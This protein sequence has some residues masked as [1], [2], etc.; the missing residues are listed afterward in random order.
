PSNP[1]PGEGEEEGVI[2]ESADTEVS[3]DSVKSVVEV[4]VGA[5]PR[6]RPS[7]VVGGSPS[8]GGGFEGRGERGPGG[9]VSLTYAQLDARSNQLAHR[10]RR[11]GVGPETLVAI[12]IERSV[13]L[14]VALL[15]ILKSGGAYLPIDPSWPSERIAYMLDDAQVPVLLTLGRLRTNLP[16]TSAVVLELDDPATLAGEPESPVV[17]AADD[18]SALA[19]VI[20]TSGSTGRPKG[21][22]NSHRGIV[23]RLLWMAPAMDLGPDDR[24]LQKTPVSFDV[25]VWELFV[26]LILGARLVYAAPGRHGDPD[27][28]VEWIEQQ[29][30]TVCHFVPSMLQAFVAAAAGIER[31]TSLRRVVASG[32]ALPPDLVARWYAR[33][34]V[35]LW[36][37][38]GPTETAVEVS[39]HATSARTAGAPVPIGRPLPNT[40]LVVIDASFRPVPPGVPGELTIGGVQVGRGYRNRPALTAAMFVPDPFGD[41]PGARMYRTGDL[42][43]A[44]PN[45][46]IE[47]LGRIDHQVKIRGFRIELGEIEA[48]LAEHP[49]VQAAVVLARPGAGGDSRLVGY[50]TVVAGGDIEEGGHGGPPLRIDSDA[51]GSLT[52]AAVGAAPRGRPPGPSLRDFLATRLPE[53][54]IPTAFVTLEAF[55]LTPSGKVDRKALPEPAEVAA[56]SGGVAPRTATEEILAGVFAEVLGVERVSADA[57]FF[58][59]GGHSL[60]ATR[61]VARLREVFAVEIP[62]RAVFERPTVAALAQTVDAARGGPLAAAPLTRDVRSSRRDRAELSFA[63]E[64]LWFLAELAPG[65][66]V[67]NIRA[68]LSLHGPLDIA[69]L[70]RALQAVVDHHDTLRTTFVTEGGRPFQSIA[71]QLAIDLAVI[72]L[73]ALPPAERESAW[74]RLDLAEQQLGFDLERGPLLR[75]QLAIL[76]AAEHRLTLTVHHIVSDGWSFGVFLDDLGRAYRGESLPP[77][78]VTY[79]DFGVWQRRELSGAALERRVD[80]WR[81]LL[82]DVPRVLELPTDRP[83]PP[84]PSGLGAAVEL[85]LGAELS[86]ALQAFA[87]HHG[88]TPFLVLLAAYGTLLGRLAGQSVVA[89]GAPVA[90]R[91]R[92][93]VAHL[94]GFFVNTL[95]LP[96]D[97]SGGVGFAELV[98]R[99]REATLAGFA[100]ADLPFEKLVEELTPQR[101]PSRNPLF[102]A[103]LTLQ[104]PTALPDLPGITCQALPRPTLTAKFDLATS[105]FEDGGRLFGV[106]EFATELFDRATVERWSGQLRTLLAAGLAHP[107]RAVDTLSLVSAAAARELV[108]AAHGRPAEPTPVT[109]LHGLVFAQIAR[110][111]AAVALA[112]GDATLTYAELGEQARQVAARLRDL[113][114]GPETGVAL[115]LPRSLELPVVLLGVLAAGGAYLPIDPGYPAERLAAMLD[116]ARPTVLVAGADLSTDLRA[117]AAAGGCRVV[118]LAD[119]LAPGPE[120]EPVRV[121]PEQAAYWLFTSGSTGRP[122]AVVVPH[123]AIVQQMVWL[124]RE[125][126][127]TAGD[128]LLQKTPMSFDASVWEFFAPL[129]AGAVLALAVPG[130]EREPAVLVTELAHHRATVLQGVPSLL[131]ALCGEPGFSRLGHL[132][133]LFSGGE[134]LAADL[135]ASLRAALPGARLVNLYGPTETTVQVLFEAWDG[136]EWPLTVAL[137][138]PVDG[139]WVAVVDPALEPVP[140]GVVGEI[141][142]GGAAVSRGYRARPA[143]TAESFV[144]D[145]HAA[146]PGARLYRTGDLGRLRADGRLEYLGRADG[147]VKLRGVRLEL[148]EV[149]AALR[150]HPALADAVAKV[151]PGAGSHQT[152]GD[153][154]LVAYYVIRPGVAAPEITALRDHLAL[155]LP[156]ALVPGGYVPLAALPLAPNGKVDRRALPPPPAGRVETKPFV[157]PRSPREQLVAEIFA[158]VLGLTEPVGAEDSF[159]ALG[160]HSLR[161]AQVVGRLRDRTGVALPLARLFDSSATPAALALALEAALEAARNESGPAAS[162]ELVVWPGDGPFPLSFGQERLWFLDR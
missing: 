17:P 120:A 28:L 22:L 132:T 83:R 95:V 79:G 85:D 123:G 115:A 152:L 112:F 69:A 124:G 58:D 18:P 111:P 135:A 100:H 162:A 141:V 67:Y 92:A 1:R 54:M 147:Q 138:R 161:A 160:G 82:A 133:A 146:L 73:A 48:A 37:L 122:K 33:L 4:A 96:V 98:G 156:E 134:A 81:T 71:E 32:E 39:Y 52:T 143:A 78:P 87:R 127:L 131:R 13:E 64:R 114:V 11:L 108:L 68:G 113:G 101:D 154:R 151:W 66:P 51:P 61:V 155:R 119:L 49:D 105:L 136:G 62:L 129:Q 57:S 65:S 41:E 15:G 38:Y 89:V 29:K 14:S 63:Q 5:A 34:D 97:R 8:P 137:G 20:Y 24:F 44:L 157:A 93:E 56:A 30:V 43:R 26:P 90:N 10:L 142:V 84:R 9:E 72:D 70:G 117:R 50:V 31:C 145:P 91:E 107:D 106:V 53:Y 80:F 23:N 109:G 104:P 130:A 149:E 60:L 126:P 99:V 42:A 158:E 47:Y 76:G 74:Q 6:G 55:P 25:S 45:G 144:P 153:E 148:G 59:L 7:W 139:A 121:A 75:A 110:T 125:F 19:Y 3:R 94:I 86:A 12:V 16:E 103:A 118:E 2:E 40:R 27:Y 35:P 46:E 159:F 150:S 88:A 21:T 77:L 116:D 36:N 128:R 102:Q 140:P